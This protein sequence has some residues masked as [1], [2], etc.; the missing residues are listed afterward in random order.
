MT[1]YTGLYKVGIKASNRVTDI[2]VKDTGGNSLPL[3]LDEYIRRGVKPDWQTLP[4][5]ED[6]KA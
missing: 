4:W 1:S 3:A 2:Q 5:A 6:Y